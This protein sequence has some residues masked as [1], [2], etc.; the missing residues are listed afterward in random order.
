MTGT[1]VFDDL[2]DKEYMIKQIYQ[3]KLELSIYYIY[4]VLMNYSHHIFF[5]YIGF[6]SNHDI[7]TIF[8][9]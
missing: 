3:F 4:G 8:F 7:S 1:S 6:M 5:K 2:E 9:R